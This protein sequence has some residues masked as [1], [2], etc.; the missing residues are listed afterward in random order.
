[1]S[2]RL[3]W[4]GGGRSIYGMRPI[5]L[6]LAL[7]LALTGLAPAQTSGDISVE[8]AWARATPAGAPTAAVY[9]TLTNK[10]RTT[11]KLTGATTPVAEVAGLH[12]D[13]MDHDVMKMR[14]LKSVDLQRGEKVMLKPGGKHIMLTGLNRPL[15]EGDHFALTLTFEHEPPLTLRVEI[16]KVGGMDHG[17]MGDMKGMEH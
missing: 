2:H 17:N 13:I 3:A 5:L 1:M 15:I 6:A 11:D 7:T 14:A 9:L 4:A 10:G 16:V 12:I 8:H